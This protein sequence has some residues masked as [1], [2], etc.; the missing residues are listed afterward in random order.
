[1]KRILELTKRFRDDE[2]GAAMVEY[3]VLL[4]IITAAV[5]VTV[6]L[7]GTWV[8]GTWEGFEAQLPEPLAVPDPT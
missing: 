7:V 3:T 8:A 5:I 2:D 1:M 6:G 4:G